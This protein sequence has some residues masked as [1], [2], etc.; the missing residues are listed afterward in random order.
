M[1]IIYF[2]LGLVVGVLISKSKIF[3][4]VK[5]GLIEKQWKEKDENKGKILELIDS[6]YSVTNN[7]VEQLLGI[8]DATATRYL[9]E[10]EE[11]GK[12]R[13]VGRTGHA[14]TYEKR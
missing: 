2:V 14:V 8:S 11:E 3:H 9:Q 5:E 13:Q 6:E 7:R 12:I 10:L 1:S 4:S